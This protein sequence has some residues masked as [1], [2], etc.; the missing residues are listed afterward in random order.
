MRVRNFDAAALSPT[1]GANGSR[2]EAMPTI[3]TDLIEGRR[4]EIASE[5]S[6][7]TTLVDSLQ[8]ELVDLD[9]TERVLSRLGRARSD[10]G[11]PSLAPRSEPRP[12]EV[13]TRKPS[14]LPTVPAMI[15]ELLEDAAK[16]ENPA[17]TPTDI[18]ELI[19]L[20]WWPE[21]SALIIRP[22]IWRM[23]QSGKIQKG[24]GGRYCSLPPV[25]LMA[26]GSSEKRRTPDHSASRRMA[27]TDAG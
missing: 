13:T 4:Q 1:D 14:G 21:A 18:T 11:L 3:S 6:R 7:L 25:S 16:S 15:L 19:R 5:I 8:K 20:K 27:K 10:A 24:S 17:L 23:W 26:T 12:P 9:A 22:T 2:R